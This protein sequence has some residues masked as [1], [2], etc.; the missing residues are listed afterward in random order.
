MNTVSVNTT[1][2]AGVA[3]G[4]SVTVAGIIVN[5]KMFGS[6][7]SLINIA[8]FAIMGALVVLAMLVCIR[9]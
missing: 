6:N 1:Q 9:D 7:L 2:V 3:L 4:L 5:V 8:A